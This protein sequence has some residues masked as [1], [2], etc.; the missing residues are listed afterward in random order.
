VHA[1]LYT[2]LLLAAHL[3]KEKK[4]VPDPMNEYT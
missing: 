3:L 4:V 2:F 1:A